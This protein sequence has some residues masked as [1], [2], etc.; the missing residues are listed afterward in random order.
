MQVFELHFNPKAKEDL[1]FESF[2]YEPE[3]VYEKKLGNLFII[4][5]LS[6]L[7][8]QNLGFLNKIAQVI[9]G[10][11]YSLSLRSPEEAL[12]ESL[13]Q[14]NEFLAE[15][16]KK[17]NVS[18]LG[19]L[20]LAVVSVK[21]LGLN[22]TKI[23][24]LKIFLFRN[25]QISDIG[26]Q[27]DYPTTTLH[28]KPDHPKKKS[29]APLPSWA[30][31][32]PYPLKIFSNIVSGKLAQADMIMILTK[33]VF[34]FFS[35]Q[36][37][38]Q[39]IAKEE[40]LD[41]KKIKE[42]LKPE[43]KQLSEISGICFLAQ[44]RAEV[45]PKY[46][47]A[48]QKEPEKLWSKFSLSQAFSPILKMVRKIKFPKISLKFPKITLP[49][50]LPKFL[51]RGLPKL[52]FPSLFQKCKMVFISFPEAVRAKLK[53]PALTKP[54]I[55]R[56][57]IGG[58][59]VGSKNLI[60][61]LI[62]IFFLL[63]GFF[64]FKGE[65]AKEIK[66]AQG[67]L[68]EVESKVS[69]A[70]NLLIIKDTDRANILFQEAWDKVLPQT[71]LG[72]PLREEALLLKKSIE[73]RLGPL[74]KLEKI[75]DPELIFVFER[76]KTELIPQRMLGFKGQL[77]F[78]N[79]FSSNLY[80]FEV[81]K[82][83]GN[84]LT[85][86]RNLKL[87]V[88]YLNSILFFSEPNFLISLKD[89]LFQEKSLEIPSADFNFDKFS[90]FRSN[91]YFLDTKSGEIAKYSL[92]NGVSSSQLW[93]NPKT[94]KAI[95]AKS[96]AVDGSIWILT[97]GNEI[98]RYYGGFYKETLKLNLFPYL[99]YPTKIWTSPTSPYLYLLE[100]KQSRIVILT[101]RGEI[102]KQYQSEKFDNLLDFAISEDGKIIYLLNGLKVYQVET[103]L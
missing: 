100:P 51:V 8:P 61:I 2:C 29:S 99:K 59:V 77:Y 40:F 1:V 79:P 23:G 58:G 74:N 92:T 89:N 48:F 101:K 86:K 69:Q 52:S 41:Q 24:N 63:I 5:E 20:N 35:S 14:G 64:I 9:K 82:K 22:F 30:P 70:E 60:L 12:R 43:E 62:L 87:G 42:I 81:D 83:I 49:P 15:E 67:S 53:I 11:Y 32:E 103:A 94:K 98:D 6:N 37:L 3:N 93:L 54:R 4:G 55:P 96:M 21:D 31:F 50:T 56:L 80:K 76:E 25:G 71:E 10:K 68:N 33:E 85:A 57:Q 28:P 13:K 65:E 72:A 18:W 26:S 66:V 84:T 44:A 34:N 78:F 27:L 38:I 17:E 36:N 47:L 90:S 97:K 102:A 7:L 45:Y 91:I 16:V 19:N 46:T 75:A 88:P 95:S 73:E 39:K